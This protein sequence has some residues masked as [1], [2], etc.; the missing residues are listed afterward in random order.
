MAVSLGITIQQNSQSV[1]D[2][3]SNVTVSVICYWTNGSY[4][5]QTTDGVPN[6]YGWLNIEGVYYQEFNSTFNDDRTTSGS[7]TIFTKTLDIVHNVEGAKTVYCS[8]RF[9]TGVSSGTVSASASQKLTDIPRFATLEAAPNFHDEEDPTITYS[10]PAGSNAATLQACISFDG[11][12]DDVAYRDIPKDGTS[13][14]F[15]LT[16]AERNVLRSATP[17]SNTLAVQFLVKTVIDDDSAQSSLTRTLTIKDPEPTIE[18]TITDSNSVTVA[19]TGDSSKLV[20][21][22]SDAAV[23]IGAAAVKGASLTG[24]KVSCGSTSLTA[25]GTI[26]GVESDT[27]V[28]TAADSRGNT[29]QKTLTPSLVAY[30]HLGCSLADNIP[31]GAGEMEVQ[32]SGNYFNGS[33]GAKSNDL[34]VFYR[35]KAAGGTYSD[36]TEMTVALNGNT[37]AANATLTGLDYKTAYTFQAYATDAL[38]TVYSLEKTVKATPV[39]EWGEEDF[40]FHVPVSA[41]RVTGLTEPEGDTDAANKQYVDDAIKTVWEELYP[42]NTVLIRFDHVSPASLYG[43]T[44]TRLKDAF[45]WAADASGT[46]GETAGEMTHTL[47]V[48]EMPNHN[49]EG[50]FYDGND[51]W[52]GLNTGTAG[53]KLSWS[54]SAGNGW[55]ELDTGYAGGGGAHNNMPP[56][57]NVSVWRRTA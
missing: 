52:V 9:A 3:T 50:I 41:E 32:A 33:F 24:Q 8:A 27:F 31:T 56:Y 38:S 39:F 17:D 29:A 19:L 1:A 43:G 47:T 44:W 46:I 36:W 22:Y 54:A 35:Y 18:P 42:V 10:N 4:N 34:K 37:Y 5:K 12:N 6:A 16:E 48:D 28:F 45:L 14:T 21:Y 57:V 25:D 20:R 7:K 23:T 53:Y 40:T 11:S 30:L 13:Y 49:H 2:N 26:Y 15:E 51:K 55:Q